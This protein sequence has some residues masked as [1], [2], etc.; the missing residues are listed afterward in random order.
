M[1]IIK[2]WPCTRDETLVILSLL[3][4]LCVTALSWWLNSMEDGSYKLLRRQMLFVL[5]AFGAVWLGWRRPSAGF[6]WWGIVAGSILIGITGCYFF[7]LETR[8]RSN[9][10]LLT[11]VNPIVFG[12][13]AVVFFAL[14][15]ASFA[16][17]YRLKPWSVVFP[18]AGI[19]LSLTAAIGSETRGAWLAL[20]VICLIAT[21]HYRKSL[22]RNPGKLVIPCCI[23]LILFFSIS[24]WEVI[25]NRVSTASKEINA[26]LQ[27]KDISGG[28]PVST[29]LDMWR[30]AFEAG[31]SSLII[32]PGKDEFRR[33]AKEGVEQ[34]RYVGDTSRYHFPHSEYLTAFGYHGIAGLCALLL[35]FLIPGH[36]FWKRMKNSSDSA[37]QALAVAGLLTVVCFAVFSLT[38][39]PFEQRPTIMFYSVMLLLPLTLSKLSIHASRECNRGH[40]G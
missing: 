5:A 27:G 2:K 6:F 15:C 39:S 35:I 9:I 19:I 26:Y 18:T 1:I 3:L 38:D 37:I 33:V 30:A 32:G 31:K 12:Q 11:Q 20:P 14:S 10:H 21:W 23:F 36:V 13:F 22:L 29:R 25:E 16:Y 40:T 8:F 28:T 7:L 34:G 17:F 4:Y 24:G